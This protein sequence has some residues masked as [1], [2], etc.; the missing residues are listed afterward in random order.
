MKHAQFLARNG[1]DLFL[2]YTMKNDI[3]LSIA[4]SGILSHIHFPCVS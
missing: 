2:A 3:R 1:L 4:S